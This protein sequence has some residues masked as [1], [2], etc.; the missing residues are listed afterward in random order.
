MGSKT[1][2]ATNN[3]GASMITASELLSGLTGGSAG[4]S[5][6]MMFGGKYISY[7]DSLA[8]TIKSNLEANWVSMAAGVILIPVVAKSVSKLIRR[9]VILPANR[10]LKAAGLDVKV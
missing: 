2:N 3:T 9:P 1:A 6:G 10:M 8:N 4:T 7:G 5:G